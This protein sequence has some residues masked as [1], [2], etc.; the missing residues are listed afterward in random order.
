MSD[1]II[2]EM[3]DSDLAGVSAIVCNCYRLLAKHEG[4]T[5]EQ[6]VH[7]Q[8]ARGSEKAIQSQRQQQLFL[9]AVGDNTLMGVASVEN[10]EL[11]K[12]YVEPG[13]H[14]RGIGKLLFREAQ[15]LILDRGYSDMYLGAFS[16]AVPFYERLGM[17]VSHWKNISRG[18]LTG[19]KQA[20]MTISLCQ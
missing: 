6:L 8:S 9:V 20:V 10:N 2:R 15:R 16:S 19:R 12:L 17:T 18:P 5:Q 3:R 13:F 4:F 7:L 11:A 1:I 14:N